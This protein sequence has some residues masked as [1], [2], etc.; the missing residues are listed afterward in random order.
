MVS[1]IPLYQVLPVVTV[2]GVLSD[3]F[4]GDVTSIWVIKRTL[5]GINVQQANSQGILCSIKQFLR[6][7][8]VDTSM[9]YL[10]M[11]LICGKTN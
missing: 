7:L 4:M 5:I 9:S 2:L 3:L 10:Q 11:V 1:I 6:I 8:S